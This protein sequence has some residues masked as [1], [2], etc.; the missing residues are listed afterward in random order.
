MPDPKSKKSA[1]TSADD[2]VDESAVSDAES[3]DEPGDV[4]DEP[5]DVTA[6]PKARP[7]KTAADAKA[8][9]AKSADTADRTATAAKGAKTSGKGKV[10]KST[11]S[12]SKASSK[13][14]G[15]PAKAAAA[16]KKAPPSRTPVKPKRIGN[17]WA[18]PAMLTS[19]GI[20]LLWIVVF[21]V[22]Q[23]TDV[24]LP[25]ITDLGSWNLVIG[26]GFIVAAF[27]FSMKWE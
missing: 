26:M 7:E 12:S 1:E 15:N 11:T 8:D 18:A 13:K 23:G 2:V 14:S 16:E 20:G 27:G 17:R 5:G 6:A 10:A 19:A 3:T 21:Y 9:D 25:L 24:T 4:T 22:T